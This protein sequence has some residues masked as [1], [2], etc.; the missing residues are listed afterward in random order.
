MG[1]Y[2]SQTVQRRPEFIPTCPEGGIPENR[3][4]VLRKSLVKN[5]S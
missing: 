1:S 2:G 4:P 3:T 5:H